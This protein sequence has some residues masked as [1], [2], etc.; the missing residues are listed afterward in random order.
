MDF[1]FI[2]LEKSDYIENINKDD[3][4]GDK[5]DDS[6]DFVIISPQKWNPL[7]TE[8]VL[9]VPTKDFFNEIVNNTNMEEACHQLDVDFPRQTYTLNNQIVNDRNKMIDSFAQLPCTILPAVWCSTQ[10]VLAYPFVWIFE[11][12]QDSSSNL[13]L[14]DSSNSRTSIEWSIKPLDS[15]CRITK[16]L[17]LATLPSS[18]TA[19]D[20]HHI[21]ISLEC[22]FEADIDSCRPVICLIQV[23][24]L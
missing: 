9:V 15:F 18:G 6:D 10:A 2:I 21:K 23:T 14:L 12:L 8:S 1:S 4:D 13:I 22:P 19:M 24:K 7:M 17:R 5:S 20:T 11:K 3:C 16:N